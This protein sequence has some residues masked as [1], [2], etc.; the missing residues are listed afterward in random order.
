M[1]RLTDSMFVL[2]KRYLL[3]CQKPGDGKGLETLVQ[4]HEEARQDRLR[5]ILLKA[6]MAS[7]GLKL[8]IQNK[9]VNTS[10]QREKK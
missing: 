2:M 7:T 10:P 8:E 5:T 1:R 3:L 9:A 6:Q 4:S